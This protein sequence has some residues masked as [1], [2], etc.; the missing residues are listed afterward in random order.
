MNKPAGG[1]IIGIIRIF[2]LL[3]KIYP[4]FLVIDIRLKQLKKSN[5]ILTD[6]KKINIISLNN[7][8]KI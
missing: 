5:Q 6:I 3:S 1:D 7:F 4:N 8:Y 2:P